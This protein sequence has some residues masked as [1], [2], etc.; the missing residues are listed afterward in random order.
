MHVG[1][2]SFTGTWQGTGQ[3]RPL[4]G[5]NQQPQANQTVLFTPGVGRLD[6]RRRERGGGRARAV[7]GRGDQ[8]RP[9]GDR[10]RDRRAARRAIPADGAVLVA[11][12]TA[13]AQ[14]PGRGAAGRHGHGAA[15]PARRLELASSRRSAAAR[16]SSRAASR[17]SRRARTSTRPTSP[18]RQ[19]RAAVGQLAD[20]RVILV[21]VDGG[22]PGY[23]VGMTNYELA[24]TM[25]KLGAVTAAGLQYGK[26]VTAAFDGQLLNRPSQ[27]AG[28]RRSRRRCSS[29]TRASTRCRRSAPVVGKATPPPASSSPT[30]SCSRRQVTA[31][32][33]RPRRREPPG[34]R[35]Q[36]AARAPTRF[37]W[38]SFDTEGTW[39]WNVQATDDQNRAS[40]ADQ[41]FVVRPDALRARRAEVGVAGA[42]LTRRLHAL[43]ARRR[44]TLADHGRERHA[45]RRRCRRSS[46]PA[47]A[48]S[49]AWDGTTAGG[50]KAPPGALRRD[51][52]RDELGRHRRPITRSF[53]PR[54]ASAPRDHLAS[55]ATTGC[56]RSSC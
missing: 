13:A 42:G 21:A 9:D 46:S 45:R 35:R 43:A 2:I 33:R 11:T 12:G 36:Q 49:L 48:Q 8:H 51:R 27:P 24:Q 20:G 53:T 29:S 38:P 6:A 37:T 10:R 54:T 14:A 25:A 4:A 18:S 17:S 22:R 23:S 34:R 41:T 55:S 15:D 50:A 31:T 7:P 16:C 3:R 44:S 28:R 47:G 39:H 26:F 19:P 5:V 32:R 40:T 1:R 56:S 30:G 52:H